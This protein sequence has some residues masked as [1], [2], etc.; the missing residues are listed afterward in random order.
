MTG[1]DEAGC[2]C[3]KERKQQSVSNARS[4]PP[5]EREAGSCF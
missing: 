3:E 1:D 2:L 4:H 5:V